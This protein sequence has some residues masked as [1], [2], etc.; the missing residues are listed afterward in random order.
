[1]PAF[2]IWFQVVAYF[3]EHDGN[4]GLADDP[5]WA[6]CKR[7]MYHDAWGICIKDLVAVQKER[8]FYLLGQKYYPVVVNISV[9]NPEGIIISRI[10]GGTFPCRVCE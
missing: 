2:S 10:S 8:G 5:S 3:P 9:D 1:M 7:Q 4:K 6:G